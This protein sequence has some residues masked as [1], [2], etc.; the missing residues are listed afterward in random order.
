MTYKSFTEKKGNWKIEKSSATYFILCRLIHW[1]QPCRK[2]G[3]RGVHALLPIP[4]FGRSV[5]PIST[6]GAH[7]AHHITT[8]FPPP[9][10]SDL[11][12]ALDTLFTTGE[13]DHVPVSCRN[14]AEGRSENP[15]GGGASRNV[16]GTVWI[17]QNRSAKT[18]GAT[19]LRPCFLPETETFLA[20]CTFYHLCFQLAV[21]ITFS[22][23]IILVQYYMSFFNWKTCSNH[24]FVCDAFFWKK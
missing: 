8:C 7:Y 1:Y 23:Q 19:V 9:G 5:N 20:D 13:T 4:V 21:Y 2:W 17:G 24:S 11:V 10:F 22:D 18:W 16:V 6:R 14:G 15:D 12:M 3:A